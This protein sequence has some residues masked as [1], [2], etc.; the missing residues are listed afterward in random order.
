MTVTRIE[1]AKATSVSNRM[2]TSRRFVAANYIA[3]SRPNV[4]PATTYAPWTTSLPFSNTERRIRNTKG[5]TQNAA[6]ENNQNKSKY[7]IASACC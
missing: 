5:A 3:L 7:D 4:L 1:I 2:H 6:I